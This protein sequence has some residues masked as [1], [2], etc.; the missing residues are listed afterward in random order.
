M[1]KLLETAYK[2]L[3]KL[4]HSPVTWETYQKIADLFVCIQCLE[5][6][7]RINNSGE[8]SE[9]LIDLQGNFGDERTLEIISIALIEF[10]KDLECVS[11][12]LA[13]CLINKIKESIK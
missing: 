4:E 1:N 10:K 5:K 7:T 2:E 8:L 11:P 12:H 13:K 3:K 6:E 9:L